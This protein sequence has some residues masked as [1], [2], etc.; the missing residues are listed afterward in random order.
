VTEPEPPGIV[1]LRRPILSVL[2]EH[3]DRARGK[4][5]ELFEET[6]AY[7]DS[8]HL[9]AESAASFISTNGMNGWIGRRVTTRC[10]PH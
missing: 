2:W 7:V 6:E 1:Q 10:T 8:S 4:F 3:P 5:T 9:N